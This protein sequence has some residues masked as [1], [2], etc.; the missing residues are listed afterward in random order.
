VQF[1]TRSAVQPSSSSSAFIRRCTALFPCRR[2]AAKK[3][4]RSS[5][6]STA[7]AMPPGNQF[8]PRRRKQISAETRFISEPLCSVVLREWAARCSPPILPHDLAGRVAN[9]YA[10]A[11]HFTA[12]GHEPG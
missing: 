11:N 8:S 4:A 9:A 10:C 2:I 5:G 1:P 7:P 12:T 6:V 3:T